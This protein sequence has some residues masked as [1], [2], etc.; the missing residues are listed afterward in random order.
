VLFAVSI[1]WGVAG[2]Y[3]IHVCTNA[4][5]LYADS[6]LYKNDSRERVSFAGCVGYLLPIVPLVLILQIMAV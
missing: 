5:R 3:N 1:W 6:Y 2:C 4:R